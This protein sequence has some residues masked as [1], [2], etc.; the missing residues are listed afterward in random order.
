MCSVPSKQKVWM[1]KTRKC[2][3]KTKNNLYVNYLY[4]CVL[5]M[6]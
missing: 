5:V 4:G 3:K 6:D 1:D 2:T